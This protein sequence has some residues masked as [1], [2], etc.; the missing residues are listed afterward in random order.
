[1]RNNLFLALFLFLSFNAMSNGVAIVNAEQGIY[2]QLVSSSV[3][4]QVQ[5]QV[6]ITTT[7]QVFRND[8][9]GAQ[10]FKYGFPMPSGG[11][12]VGLR[13]KI[14]GVWHEADFNAEAQDTTLPGPGG[15]NVNVLL[16]QYLGAF[17]LYFQIE[18][19]LPQDSLITIELS[20]VELLPYKNGTVTYRYPG[21]YL[22][23]QT[24]NLVQQ[25]FD[26]NL[27]SGRKIE[28][29]VFSS[30]PNVT[31][32]KTDNQASIQHDIWEQP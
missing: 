1:M 20:Y 18:N 6:S 32:I 19:P 24:D 31:P 21:K 8:L 13:W 15:G 25:H 10:S 11:S 16:S 17:P 30:H 9:F 28:T 26:F 3:Q 2:L 14:G 4:V 12:A 7:A 22:N 27:S 29:V 23:I 5:N